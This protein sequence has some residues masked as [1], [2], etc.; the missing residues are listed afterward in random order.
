MT[1]GKGGTTA[2]HHHQL[3]VLPVAVVVVAD[4]GFGSGRQPPLPSKCA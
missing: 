2:S 4:G 3:P 1:R